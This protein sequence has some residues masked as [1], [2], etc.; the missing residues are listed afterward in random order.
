MMIML[1]VAPRLPVSP[2]VMIMLAV[3]GGRLAPVK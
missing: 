3:A 1:A 2:D